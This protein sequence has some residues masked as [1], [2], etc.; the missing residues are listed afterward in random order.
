LLE[1]SAIGDI[2]RESNASP[3][4]ILRNIINA[5]SKRYTFAPQI[6]NVTEDITELSFS[7]Q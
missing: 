3:E 5:L 6:I 7:A 2:V 1:E 4:K